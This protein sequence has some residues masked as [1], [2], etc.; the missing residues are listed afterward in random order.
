MEQ[1]ASVQGHDGAASL[2]FILYVL[3][4]Y[5]DVVLQVLLMTGSETADG[6]GSSCSLGEQ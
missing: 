2:L 5:P 6:I 1:T 3:L 4:H